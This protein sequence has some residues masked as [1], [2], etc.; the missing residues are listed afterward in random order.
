MY[1]MQKSITVF[2]ILSSM[3]LFSQEKKGTIKVKK[4]NV[5]IEEGK[6]VFKKNCAMCHSEYTNRI[7]GP[8]LAGVIE[9]VPSMEWL[10]KWLQNSQELI[11]L[12]DPYA[13]KLSIHLTYP[14]LSNQQI[15]NIFE[16]VNSRNKNK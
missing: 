9:K 1:A 4:D 8:G 2:F 3:S 10:I 7:T 13:T 14:Y 12:K 11:E 16:Y 15:K 5:S 6:T